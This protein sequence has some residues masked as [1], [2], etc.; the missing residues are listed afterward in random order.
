MM[1]LCGQRRRT[2]STTQQV[3]RRVRGGDVSAKERTWTKLTLV[4][5]VS[6]SWKKR[7][8][9]VEISLVRLIVG[10]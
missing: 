8:D 1:E 4:F 5:W 7:S 2:R 10:D 3:V 9:G 6:V